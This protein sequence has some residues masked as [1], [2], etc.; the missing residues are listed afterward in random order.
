MGAR[1]P[2]HI[3]LPVRHRP[4]GDRRGAQRRRR[5]RWA[6][7]A[8]GR[9][10]PPTKG[11]LVEALP[12]DGV[13]VLNADDPLVA[14]M[15]GA[16]PGPGGAGRARR[17][18]PTIRAADVTARRLRPGRASSWSP[19]TAASPVDARPARRAHVGNALAAAAVGAGR[20]AAAGADRGRPGRGA[21]RPAAGGWRS[22]SAPDGVIVVNDA[23]NANPD[24]V[25]AAL[26]ALAAMRADACRRTWAV[27]G[28]MLELGADVRGRAR[29]AGPAGGTAGHRPAGRGR[30][31]GA[32]GGRRRGFDAAAVDRETAG[33]GTGPSRSGWPTAGRPGLLRTELRPA[34]SSWSRRPGRSAWTGWPPPCWRATVWPATAWPARPWRAAREGGPDRRGGLAGAARCSAPRS[35]SGSWSG[36]ATAS[37]SATTGRPRTT[38]SAAPRRWAAP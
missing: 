3:A 17:R 12:G 27:L 13:A 36:A 32:P 23:Y 1:G 28:E 22:G 18:R 15:A 4:A 5:A 38:P 35:T 20:R 21:A 34:T 6:S 30:R 26:Q 7:S 19:P 2:G 11:E 10:P 14:A 25:R 29:R 33:P 31:G 24:S 8:A 9:R 16:H 37:S